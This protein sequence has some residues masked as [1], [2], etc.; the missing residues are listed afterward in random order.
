MNSRAL[1]PIPISS[2]LER[3]FCL[4]IGNDDRT[5]RAYRGRPNGVIP[6]PMDCLYFSAISEVPRVWWHSGRTRIVPIHCA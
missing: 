1:S 3:F 5:R 4:M 2:L 6:K